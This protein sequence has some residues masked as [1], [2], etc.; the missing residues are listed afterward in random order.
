M[1][2]RF[3]LEMG[4]KAGGERLGVECTSEARGGEQ[5]GD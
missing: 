3:S 2:A 5:V 4:E 1:Q